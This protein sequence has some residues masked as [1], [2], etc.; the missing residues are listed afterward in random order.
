MATLLM[1]SGDATERVLKLKMGLNR[2]GR[3][4]GNDIQIEHP[5]VSS[6]HCEL[7][8]AGGD[9]AVRDCGSTNGTFIEGH[10]IQVAKLCAGQVLV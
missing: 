5:S 9:I 4:P 10:P 2:L 3:R 1:K 6:L 7:E 8:L